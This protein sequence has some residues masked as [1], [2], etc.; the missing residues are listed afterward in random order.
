MSSRVELAI[1]ELLERVQETT[2]NGIL[3]R[4]LLHRAL[5]RASKSDSAGSS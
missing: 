3:D 1:E 2:S 4:R 5:S